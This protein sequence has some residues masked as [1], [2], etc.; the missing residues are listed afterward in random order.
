[1]TALILI[2]SLLAFFAIGMPIVFA[3]GVST[4][5]AT[6]YQG[7][8]PLASLPQRMFVSLDNWVT[9]A[10][11]LFMLAGNLMTEGGMSQRI[12]DFFNEVFR[13]IRAGLALINVA[14][15]M[16]FAG[17]SG[18]S[19]ADT[20]AIGSIMFPIMKKAGYNMK[21]ATALQSAAGSIGPVIPPSILMILIGFQTE[22]SIAKLF[23]GGLIP[24][25]LIGIGLM[26]ISYFHVKMGG[27]DYVP[28]DKVEPFSIKRFLLAGWSAL[29]GLGLPFIIIFGIITGIF[30]ATEAA[31]VA[32]VYG[33]FVG[34]F[35]YRELKIKN[36]PRIFMESAKT[37]CV[38]MIIVATASFFG[39]F[40]A[41]NQYTRVLINF[42]SIY[43]KSV[44]SFLLFLNIFLL[45][46]G[47]FMESYT[48]IIV[49]MP[50]FF[51]IAKMYGIDPV[52]FGVIVCVNLAIGYITP[53][54][55]ATLYVACGLTG[56]SVR[57]VTPYILPI[58]IM[59]VIVLL[60]ITYFPNV[61]MWVPNMLV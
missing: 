21:W 52:H 19:T 3:I 39:W 58:F 30:T 40:V 50:I 54:Y 23:L 60:V 38:I 45:I 6:I 51:P 18:S 17:V 8:L 15:S 43:V 25:V 47:C 27:E 34:I 28:L 36:L 20:A 61:F 13:F 42:M 59:M 22:T 5:I 16:L 10:I 1:M 11:P 56:K 26:I 33:L 32:V 9:I 24:G 2:L 37:A 29:P 53:P 31:V 55:G 7:T 48:A 44:Y 12:V 57:E 14:A 46:V 4:L 41:I 35:I 49:L